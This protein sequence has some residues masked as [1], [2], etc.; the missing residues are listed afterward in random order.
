[1]TTGLPSLTPRP[2][3]R[4]YAPQTSNRCRRPRSFSPHF[5][6]TK[7]QNFILSEW[8]A[9]RFV[10]DWAGIP[11]PQANVSADGMTAAALQST[12]GQGFYPGIEAGIIATDKTIYAQPFDFRL[13]HAQVRPGDLTALM[14]LPWQAD[15]GIAEAAGGPRNVQTKCASTLRLRRGGL[16]LAARIAISR[17]S[18]ISQSL[19]SSLHSATPGGISFSPKISG[20]PKNL[21]A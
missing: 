1:V 19:R 8:S 2:P 21:F 12:V 10:S 17:W 11:Q 4:S 7:L 5:R 18:T 13:N 15:S 14:A 16:G 6:L 20:R 3:P 9:G